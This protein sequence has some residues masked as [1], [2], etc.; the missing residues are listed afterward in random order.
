MTKRKIEYG[1]IPPEHDGEFVAC[2]EEVLDTYAQAYE[3]RQP[4]LGMDEQPVQL[5]KETRGPL[6]P[7]KQPG[8]RVDDEYERNGTASIFL[9]AGP[10][11]GFRQA[12]ARARRTKEDW[13]LEV[14]QLLDGR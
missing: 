3:P 11:S 14:A 1:V 13:A 6:P 7:T 12:A 2:T 10:L 4:V 9:F 8:E 5:P